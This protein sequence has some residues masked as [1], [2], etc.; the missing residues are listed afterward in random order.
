MNSHLTFVYEQLADLLRQSGDEE[1][2]Q[3]E[4]RRGLETALRSVNASPLSHEAWSR[5]A[6]LRWSLGQYEEADK[7]EKF[8][9]ELTQNEF[10]GGDSGAII[11]SR[12][13]GRTC[14][15]L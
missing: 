6:S 11:T 3:R 7:A 15:S 4:L 8:A 13:G 5:V 1:G 14:R 10:Y 9:T 12:F 2:A